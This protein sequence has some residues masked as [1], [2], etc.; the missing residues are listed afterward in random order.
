MRIHYI[1]VEYNRLTYYWK[2]APFILGA[3]IV[4]VLINKV[5]RVFTDSKSTYVL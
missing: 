4:D 1:V 2:N 5:K 3:D